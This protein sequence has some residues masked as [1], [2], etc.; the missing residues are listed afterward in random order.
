MAGL[1]KNSDGLY[2][3]S[4]LFQF[5]RVELDL[6]GATGTVTPD[7][8]IY[9]CPVITAIGNLTGDVTLVLPNTVGGI[10]LI[11]NQTYTHSVSVKTV[12]GTV[13]TPLKAGLNTL[14]VEESLVIRNQTK[15]L[16]SIAL[17][18]TNTTLTISQLIDAEFIVFTGTLTAGRTITITPMNLGLVYIK[19][20]AGQTLTLSAP[21]GTTT[22]ANGAFKVIYMTP[23]TMYV[24]N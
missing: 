23:T 7:S 24:L 22:V 14:V 6:D 16:K 5:N 8:V 18:D 13:T 4:Q 11:D 20:S 1:G 15:S 9:Q 19:N 21:S 12:G 17:P 3:V 10:V 2:G